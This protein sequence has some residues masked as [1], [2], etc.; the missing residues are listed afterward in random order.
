MNST[1]FCN[2]LKVL[3]FTYLVYYIHL[4]IHSFNKHILILCARPSLI[5]LFLCRCLGKR[6]GEGSGSKTSLTHGPGEWGIVINVR[7]LFPV[8]SDIKV[9]KKPIPAPQEK[10]VK[11]IKSCQYKPN[12][13]IQ[14]WINSEDVKDNLFYLGV[15]FRACVYLT[16]TSL[17]MLCTVLEVRLEYL[18]SN[19][20][21]LEIQKKKNLQV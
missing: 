14:K 5:F 4:F 18:A 19:E 13:I 6:I 11:K 15:I 1:I 8:D 7:Y 10:Y 17:D 2:S 21:Y 3:L 12:K 9:R 20:R 16:C